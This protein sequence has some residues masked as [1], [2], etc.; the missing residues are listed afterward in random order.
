MNAMQVPVLFRDINTLKWDYGLKMFIKCMEENNFF[1]NAIHFDFYKV[2]KWI[3]SIYI[4]HNN[5]SING[6]VRYMNDILHTRI[7]SFIQ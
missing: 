7:L 3:Y 1:N 6:A 5:L 4:D 2:D